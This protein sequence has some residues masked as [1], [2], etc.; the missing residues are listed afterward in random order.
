MVA[1]KSR[2]T[3]NLRRDRVGQKTR[4]SSP[5][6]E[7]PQQLAK[8]VDAIIDAGEAQRL[9]DEGLQRA[10]DLDAELALQRALP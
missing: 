3:P 10:H 5:R 4:R 6:L 1:P 8:S 9:P 7:L 2:M